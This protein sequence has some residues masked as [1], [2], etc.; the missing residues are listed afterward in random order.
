[1][2]GTIAGTAA[3]SETILTPVPTRRRIGLLPTAAGLGLVGALVS[4]L[5]SWNPSYW[6]DEAASVLSA[7]RPLATL[8]PE[9]GRV[10]AVHGLYYVFLHFWIRV[11]GA[12]ELSTRLPSAIA[13][14]LA[15]AGVVVLANL[16]MT[17]AIGVVAG[18]VFAVLPRVT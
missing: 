8:W 1:M 3:A 10:D 12:S 16:L 5:G 18:I 14:G 4:F 13:I 9:L 15:A 17:R 2:S 7:E 11:F 6:G